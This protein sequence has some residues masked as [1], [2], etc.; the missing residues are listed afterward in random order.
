MFFIQVSQLMYVHEKEIMD[1]GGRG[2]T[3]EELSMGRGKSDVDTVFTYKLLP[4]NK[5]KKIIGCSIL[6]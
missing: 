4:Q 5:M 2:G 6:P 1:L 3:W